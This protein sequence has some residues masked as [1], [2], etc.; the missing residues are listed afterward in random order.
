MASVVAA[1]LRP[2]AHILFNSIYMR[3]VDFVCGSCPLGCFFLLFV[4]VRVCVCVLGRLV[5]LFLW[6][7]ARLMFVF[8]LFCVWSGGGHLGCV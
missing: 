1:Q 3:S 7:G 6:S 4:F 5:S 8:D 2:G